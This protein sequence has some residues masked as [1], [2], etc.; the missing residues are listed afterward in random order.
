MTRTC[1]RHQ[2]NVP[3]H[4]DTCKHCDEPVDEGRHPELDVG[5]LT[6]T[7]RF[8]ESS[9]KYYDDAIEKAEDAPFY[10]PAEGDGKHKAVFGP[11]TLGEAESL[12]DLTSGWSSSSMHINGEEATKKNLTYYGV[13]CFRKMLSSGDGRQYCFGTQWPRFNIWGCVRLD[14]PVTPR[15][16]GWMQY[17]HFDDEGNW[18]FDKARIWNELQ[19]QIEENARCPLLDLEKVRVAVKGLPDEVD[20]SESPAWFSNGEQPPW[21]HEAFAESYDD[22]EADG[23]F[24]DV[25]KVNRYTAGDYTPTPP[26]TSKEITAPD[27][28]I[29][30][31]PGEI[32]VQDDQ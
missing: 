29:S 9:S 28:V 1:E 31:G 5:P 13:G 12:W 24:A 16:G 15:G 21:G 3:D 18:H 2:R 4:W 30:F 17:G 10:A 20:L 26:K 8:G 23:L 11:F 7:I 19:E 14:M 32:D 27:A 25:T 6:V 22:V